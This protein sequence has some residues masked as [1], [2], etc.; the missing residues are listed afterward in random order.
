M[1]LDAAYGTDIM[2]NIL[3]ISLDIVMCVIESSIIAILK[4]ALHI[5]I[6]SITVVPISPVKSILLGCALILDLFPM[7]SWFC[8]AN[9][10]DLGYIMVIYLYWN[11]CNYYFF[12]FKMH[13]EQIHV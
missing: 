11:L 12:K 5:P 3:A 9:F 10:C 4:P 13:L 1:S 7:W 2:S 8:S 6:V